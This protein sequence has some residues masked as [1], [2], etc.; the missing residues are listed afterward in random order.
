MKAKS[1]AVSYLRWGEG[2]DLDWRA[3]GGHRVVSLRGEG[4]AA[5]CAPAQDGGWCGSS[6]RDGDELAFTPLTELV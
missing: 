5:A 4:D 2:Q 1:R 6:R 3:L